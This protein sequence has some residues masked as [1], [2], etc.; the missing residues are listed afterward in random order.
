MRPAAQVY[1]EALFTAS[2]YMAGRIPP[3]HLRDKSRKKGGTAAMQAEAQ[4]ETGAMGRVRVNLNLTKPKK[5]KA[6]KVEPGAMSR[7]GLRESGRS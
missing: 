1:E 4:V 2:E 5:R 7:A 3:R 6:L